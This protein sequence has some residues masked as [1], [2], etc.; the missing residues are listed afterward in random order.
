M[1]WPPSLSTD[2]APWAADAF[3]ALCYGVTSIKNLKVQIK[4]AAALTVPAHRRYYGDTER[5]MTVWH[6]L[7]AALENSED[8]GSFVGYNYYSSLRHTLAE[9]LLHLLSVSQSQDM[10]ALGTSLAGEEGRTIREHLINYLREE[11]GGEDADGE[12]VDRKNHVDPQ[13]RIKDLQQ[14][15]NRLKSLDTE[16]EESGKTVVVDFLEDLLKSCE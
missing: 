9:A 8:T 3:S 1:S 5:F 4:S 15:V 6:S 2:S 14:N 10:A 7:A 11:G 16:G 13:Q 12:E